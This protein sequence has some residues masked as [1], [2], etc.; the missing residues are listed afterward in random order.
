MGMMCSVRQKGHRSTVKGTAGRTPIMGRPHLVELPH[1]ASRTPPIQEFTLLL[2]AMVLVVSGAEHSTEIRETADGHEMDM[3]ELNS[4]LRARGSH[5]SD[6]R[7]A[8]LFTVLDRDKN[9][10]VSPK[11]VALVERSFAVSARLVCHTDYRNV[12][13]VFPGCPCLPREG[14]AYGACPA[15]YQCAVQWQ[16]DIWPALSIN[17]SVVRSGALCMPCTLGQHCPRGSF[18]PPPGPSATTYVLSHLCRPGMQCPMPNV[19]VRCPAGTFCGRGAVVPT[20]C[21]YVNLL[22]SDPWTIVPTLQRTV[23]EHVYL[24]GDPMAGN[25]CPAGSETLDTPC[26]AGYFCP[27]SSTKILCPA[28]KFCKYSSRQPR[29]CPWLAHCKPGAESADLSLGGFLVLFI[30]LG[31]LFLAYAAL[32][33]YIRLQQERLLKKQAAQDKLQQLVA[34]L[35]ALHDPYTLAF[36]AFGAIRPRITLRFEEMGVRLRD[37][38]VIL[39]GVTGRFSHSTVTAVM[40]PSGAGKSTLL[41]CLMGTSTYGR[42][43]G[44]LWVN[45]R[46]M[47]LSRLRRVMGYVPQDDIVHE[48]LTVRENLAYSAWL[49]SEKGMKTA[50]KG[51]VVDDVIDLLRLRHV[52]HSLVG[53]VEKRGISGGQ[54]KRVNIGL[55][56]VAKPSL[57]FMDEPTSGLDATAATDILGA[58]RRMADLGM[59]I[60]VVIHQPRFTVYSLFHE[61][62]CSARR[63][64]PC[65]WDREPAPCP[66][67]S[68]SAST[69]RLMKTQLIGSLT[70]FPGSCPALL[71]PTSSLRICTQH[72]RERGWSGRAPL[73]QSKPAM[74][75]PRVLPG[76]EQVPPSE[77]SPEQLQLVMQHFDR[78][79]EGACEERLTPAAIRSFLLEMGLEP[80]AFEMD[81]IINAVDT[82]GSGTISRDD[83]LGFIRRGGRSAPSPQGSQPSG[84]RWTQSLL[85]G[86]SALALGPQRAA[87][88]DTRGPEQAE[89]SGRPDS[90]TLQGDGGAPPQTSAPVQQSTPV[91]LGLPVPEPDARDL[92]EGEPWT[93]RE[94]Q[95]ADEE[96]AAYRRGDGVDPELATSLSSYMEGGARRGAA[97]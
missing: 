2:L 16:G 60:V 19:T 61:Y 50:A 48:D 28:G 36:N 11:E 64:V 93:T 4:W 8:H 85:P 77:L 75:P 3:K 54:R 27:N 80:S 62:S 86:R 94:G 32:A 95:P 35:L 89:P 88:A 73:T 52:Q 46:E 76:G 30:I 12:T 74:G 90:G 33:A 22:Q 10:Y 58:L 37:G 18:Q 14:A 26:E 44:R 78:V 20:T 55:E 13:Q 25:Y 84:P 51:Q 91:R 97:F 40:G 15:G 65:F 6:D 31:L 63:D 47:R 34:P 29:N 41:Y 82:T 66:T 39:D 23:R 56:L 87:G 79:V 70:S 24:M 5:L 45:G 7:L 9:G 83:F 57:L 96:W 43:T 1:R 17:S 71:I 69:C 21:S 81:H 68:P 92:R 49:R 42:T 59:T 38:A 72:G 67:S 53:S